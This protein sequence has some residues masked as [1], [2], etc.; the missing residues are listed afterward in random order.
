MPDYSKAEKEA[1]NLLKKIDSIIPPVYVDKIIRNQGLEIKR[2]R[3]KGDY[4]D[5]SGFLDIKEKSIYVNI[6]ESYE[7][8]NFTKAHELG[9]WILHRE[10]FEHDPNKQI[11]LR[12][13][14]KADGQN[15]EEKEANAFAAK[16]LI[17]KRLLIESIRSFPKASLS[18][19]ARMFQVSCEFMG[20]RIEDILRN[21]I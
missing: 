3:F 12:S 19:L 13:K 6:A 9:H 18:D 17:P 8:Q 5:V 7:R 11:L 20:Y 15:D 21:G 10:L 16:L 1:T 2:V 14:A 4:E